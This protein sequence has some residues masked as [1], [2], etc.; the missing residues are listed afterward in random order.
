VKLFKLPAFSHF[1]GCV[2]VSAG[3]F[4]TSKFD[5]GVMSISQSKHSKQARNKSY[6]KNYGRKILTV[7]TK[8]HR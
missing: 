3:I 7:E 6:C 4:V 8:G 5:G 1:N 2:L